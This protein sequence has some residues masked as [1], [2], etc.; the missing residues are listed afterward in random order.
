[1]TGTRQMALDR[2]GEESPTTRRLAHVLAFLAANPVPVEILANLD[3]TV[4]GFHPPTPPTH[5]ERSLKTLERLSLASLDEAMVTMG[6]TVGT[7]LRDQLEPEETNSACA[8]ALDTLRSSFPEESDEVSNWPTCELLLPHVKA[9]VGHAEALG[10]VPTPALWLLDRAAHFES[11]RGLYDH[12]NELIQRALVQ[13]SGSLESDDPLLGTIHHTAGSILSNRGILD[14]AQREHERALAIHRAALD[15]DDP[16]ILSDLTGLAASQFELGSGAQMVEELE[17]ALKARAGRD[18]VDADYEALGALGWGRMTKKE[19]AGAR[20]AYEDAVAL[21][22]KLAGPDHPDTAT[23]R[24]GLGLAHQQDGDLDLA[25]RELEQAAALTERSLGCGHPEVAIIR[26]NLAG[27]LQTVG[28]FS[29]S[30]RQLE[31]ALEAGKERLPVDHQALWIRHRK[32][33]AVLFTLRSY[34]DAYEHAS[35]AL[36]ITRR[37]RGPTDPRVAM[38]LHAV[39]ELLAALGRTGDALDAYQEALAIVQGEFG[40]SHPEAATLHSALGR[41]LLSARQLPAA[42]DHFAAALEIHRNAQEPNDS[43]A[44]IAR[45]NLVAIAAELG[46]QTAATYASLDREDDVSVLEKQLAKS[47]SSLLEEELD[48]G[49]LEPLLTLA[50]AARPRDLKIARQALERAEQLLDGST[51]TP[52]QRQLASSWHR[53]AGDLIRARQPDDALR[54]LENCARLYEGV[55]RFQGI[56]LEDIGHVLSGKG[57]TKKAAE[58]FRR[59]ARCRRDDASDDSQANDLAATLLAL[60]RAL[61]AN[62]DLSDANAAH[63]ERMEILTA[64]PERDSQAEGVTLHDLGNVARNGQQP[65]LAAEYYERAAQRKREAQDTNGTPRDLATTLLQ[66]GRA[67]LALGRLDAALEAHEERLSILESLPEREPRAEGITLHDLGEVRQARDE[68][69]AAVA[70]YKRAAERKRESESRDGEDRATDLAD[71]ATTLFAL[72][73]SAEKTKE[74]EIALTAYRDL[75]D[76]LE[77][78]PKRD[79]KAEGV[80]LHD[81]G[82]VLSVKE[83][84]EEAAEAYQRAAERKREGGGDETNPANLALTLFALGGAKKALNHRDEALAAFEEQLEILAA[85]DNP[86]PQAEGMTLHDIG[87]LLRETGRPG[88]ALESYERALERKRHGSNDDRPT[89]SIAETLIA[90]AATELELNRESARAVEAAL[91]ASKLVEDDDY[92]HPI[93]L[94]LAGE[95]ELARNHEEAARPILEAANQTLAIQ[96]DWTSSLDA[97]AAKSLLVACLRRVDDEQAARVAS[98]EATAMI[99][100]AVDADAV[101]NR[102]EDLVTLCTLCLDIGVP[103]LA[104]S[105]VGSVRGLAE[106]ERD[107]RPAKRLLADLLHVVGRSRELGGDD[108]EKAHSAYQER[109]DILAELEENNPFLEG[110]T[111]HDLGDVR[112]AQDRLGEAVE[113]YRQAADR[114]RE[115]SEAAEN[116]GLLTVTLA[117]LAHTEL[118]IDDLTAASR[119]GAE[120]LELLRALEDPDPEQFIEILLLTA[121]AEQNL[122]DPAAAIPLLEEGERL[123]GET[124]GDD[125]QLP[126]VRERLTAARQAVADSA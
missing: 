14:Q 123:I 67:N 27:V 16:R 107:T 32:L 77:Q 66:L 81:I 84:I 75:L 119:H 63:E 49:H 15:P 61:T 94:V 30:R 87:D 100:E 62:G 117:Q 125:S 8:A 7:A 41:T 48:S 98:E 120:A 2:L 74:Y 25:R 105:V 17:L 46:A 3:A 102:S 33:A 50:D 70:L 31:M 112:S 86:D 99:G 12:A 20:E 44:S 113:L 106:E 96:G 115:S 93:A 9:T 68:I 118:R 76:S 34:E 39:A 82:D 89:H 124:A 11:A 47:S 64:L 18:P 35:Q 71:L 79:C 108:Y 21:A 58:Y 57:D 103:D 36:A 22:T 13:A 10:D 85:S 5:L 1:M 38:D 45:I 6:N 95:A 29:E 60:G 19:T 83:Q 51:S 110:V 52:A 54:A 111:L 26:S 101:A 97:A 109:L 92:L 104:D 4:S 126:K 116:P 114:K 56:A 23:L 69:P 37:S 91:E 80:A 55:P 90:L 78:L 88:E 24:G 65:E 121:E 59:A 53:V 28:D 122:G 72:G 40:E 42:R 43:A 73:R